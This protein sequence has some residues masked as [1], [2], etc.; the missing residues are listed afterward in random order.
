MTDLVW[1]PH[2]RGS[3]W[4]EAL[5]INQ[6]SKS[7]PLNHEGEPFKK[8]RTR[9]QDVPPTTIPVPHGVPNLVNKTIGNMTVVG[10]FKKKL[11]LKESTWLV[12]IND[13]PIYELWKHKELR[14]ATEEE[15]SS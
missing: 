10:F 7:K 5:R 6:V 15:G 2:R 9:F 3:L 4:Q 8:K 13:E 14:R 11:S 12:K 1:Y